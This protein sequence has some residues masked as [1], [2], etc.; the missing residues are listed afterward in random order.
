MTSQRKNNILKISKEELEILSLIS[1]GA[2]GKVN[3]LFTKKDCQNPIN[4]GNMDYT[5]TFAPEFFDK[6]LLQSCS[7]ILELECDGKIV[8]HIKVSDI[9]KNDKS[10][11]SIFNPFE[12]ILEEREYCIGGEIKIYSS[13]IYKELEFVKNHQKKINAQKITSLVLDIDPLHRAHELMIRWSIDKA[14]M[15]VVFITNRINQLDFD[16]RVGAFKRFIKKYL[17]QD[18][19]VYVELRNLKFYGLNVNPALE[20]LLVKSFGADKLVITQNHMGVGVFY[21][22]NHQKT[23]LDEYAKE[24]GIDLI[25]L[26]EIVFCTQCQTIVSIKSCPHGNHH[27]IKYRSDIIKELLYKGLIPPSVLLRSEVS[28]FLLA[29]LHKNRFKDIGMFCSGLFTNSGLIE[30]MSDEEF[31]EGISK[32]YRTSYLG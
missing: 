25:I 20:C 3:Y 5:F 23:M 8:G 12:C 6:K 24:Y 15:I 21:D 2:F 29:R 1:I 19:V 10:Y 30:H 14:D 22:Q 32:L 16:L 4:I 13:D 11:S 31:Y 28:S 27:H 18:K 26:P 17:P 9:F 7:D